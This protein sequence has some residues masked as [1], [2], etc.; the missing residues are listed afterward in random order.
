MQKDKGDRTR[1]M[2]IGD[3]H[4]KMGSSHSRAVLGF[5]AITGCKQTAKF[6]EKADKKML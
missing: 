5:H 1:N 6:S 3:I 4:E 2:D